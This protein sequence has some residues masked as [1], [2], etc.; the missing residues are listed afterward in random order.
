MRRTR[1]RPWPWRARP[2]RRPK[3]ARRRLVRPRRAASRSR[4]RRS[5]PRPESTTARQMRPSSRSAVSSIRGP[6]CSSALASRLSRAAA[7]SIRSPSTTASS[8]SQ[9]SA[10]DLPTI[11][12][13]ARQRQSADS[14]SGR[15]AIV[16]RAADPAS[17]LISPSSRPSAAAAISI[18]PSA[19]PPGPPPGGVIRASAC[20]GRRSS[21][22]C[23]FSAVRRRPSRTAAARV[24]PAPAPP[25]AGQKATRAGVSAKSKVGRSSI[26]MQAQAL[27]GAFLAPSPTHRGRYLRRN[28]PL[29]P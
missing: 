24:A 14:S 19:D 20:S 23:S 17:P 4:A 11:V 10:I 9:R 27:G 2:E 18:G 13:C 12:A 6:P 21:W 7:R 3:A 5:A 26:H 29:F 15:T 25:T 16:A 1:R 22:R 8:P 28:R